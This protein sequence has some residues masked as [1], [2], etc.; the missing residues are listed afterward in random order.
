VELVSNA[1]SFLDAYITIIPMS[2]L[3][4]SSNAYSAGGIK[5][6][7]S[8]WR[9]RAYGLALDSFMQQSG[10]RLELRFTFLL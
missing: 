8:N 6:K 9:T 2:F 10:R 3:S 1:F 7:N 5:S 4:V